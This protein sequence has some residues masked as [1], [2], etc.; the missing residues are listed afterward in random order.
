ML[1]GRFDL[2]KNEP[3]RAAASFASPANGRAGSGE[4]CGAVT[5]RGS[6]STRLNRSWLWKFPLGPGVA[7]GQGLCDFIFRRVPHA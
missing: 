5:D 3:L 6:G 1:I 4:L 7:T 2:F